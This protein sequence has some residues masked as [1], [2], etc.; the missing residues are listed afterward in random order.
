MPLGTATVTLAGAD[1]ATPSFT[2]P[3]TVGTQ[4]H[5]RVTVTGLG[6][7][8]GSLYTAEQRLSLEVGDV[9]GLQSLAV[10]G[11]DGTVDLAPFFSAAHREYRAALGGG[12]RAGDGAGAR[13]V[14]RDRGVSGRG[15]HGAQ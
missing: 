10:S 12:G 11:P 1:T 13:N 14:G 2:A 5:V 4:L 3:A 8:P 15:R 7:A 6:S 9:L